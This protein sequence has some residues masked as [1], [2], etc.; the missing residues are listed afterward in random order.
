MKLRGKVYSLIV[1]G[2]MIPF[3][4]SSAAANPPKQPFPAPPVTNVTPVKIVVLHDTTPPER[5]YKPEAKAKEEARTAPKRAR[6]SNVRRRKVR[7][8]SRKKRVDRSW[9]DQVLTN[10]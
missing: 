5:V 4:I 9:R 3:S 2:M 1:I 6:V 7:Y 10:F 8:R